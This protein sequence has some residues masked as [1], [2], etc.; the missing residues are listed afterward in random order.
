M[1]VDGPTQR[2]RRRNAV[3]DPT[4]PDSLMWE[5]WGPCNLNLCTVLQSAK[6]AH[7]DPQRD[8]QARQMCQSHHRRRLSP[9]KSQAI[10]IYV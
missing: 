8:M 5:Y 4:F 9:S 7:V 2:F 1:S 3:K 10:H 6:L